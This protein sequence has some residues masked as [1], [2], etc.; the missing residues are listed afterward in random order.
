MF[1]T[2]STLL[3]CCALPALG[4]ADTGLPDTPYDPARQAAEDHLRSALDWR[5]Y[6]LN[7]TTGQ[8]TATTRTWQEWPPGSGS[9]QERTLPDR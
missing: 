5:S 7:Q 6:Y 9:P 4:T 8:P 2:L 3:L 1:R